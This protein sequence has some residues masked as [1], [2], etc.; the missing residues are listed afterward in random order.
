[1]V[2]ILYSIVSRDPPIRVLGRIEADT[3]VRIALLK[4]VLDRGRK[5]RGI[6]NDE[7]IGQ[8][9]ELR[10]LRRTLNRYKYDPREGNGGFTQCYEVTDNRR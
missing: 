3:E 10:R 5:K 8:L 7:L 9:K 2:K 6:M 1:M 4:R